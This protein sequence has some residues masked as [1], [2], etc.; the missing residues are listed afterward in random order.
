MHGPCGP[1]LHWC[2]YY[3]LPIRLIDDVVAT[4]SPL[5]RPKWRRKRDEGLAMWGP[6]FVLFDV[7]EGPGVAAA[8]ES[9]YG[10]IVPNAIRLVRNKL[11]IGAPRYRGNFAMFTGGGGVACITPKAA[12]HPIY[13]WQR[14]IAHEVGHCL[15]LEHGGNGIMLG[16]LVPNDH[17]LE[18]VRR[19]YH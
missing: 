11:P 17:D 3:D 12:T 6:A 8:D 2:P 5:R 10:F 19:Y 14:V 9:L 16:G 7:E 13:E 1:E 15:G 4:V 18:S